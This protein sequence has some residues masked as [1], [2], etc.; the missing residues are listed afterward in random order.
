[1]N[2]YL[3]EQPSLYCIITLALTTTAEIQAAREHFGPRRR[4]QRL[5]RP[6][7]AHGTA[8][9]PRSGRCRL[10][11]DVPAQQPASAAPCV[12]GPCASFGRPR[13]RHPAQ[14][15][16]LLGFGTTSAHAK[17][18]GAAALAPREGQLPR[19]SAA[20]GVISSSARRITGMLRF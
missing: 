6:A 20:Q 12:S 18:R 2:D 8:S 14:R 4:Q 13:R 11:P 10:R 15:A 5:L 9:G 3:C 16:G 7:S 19:P 1:M 17:A